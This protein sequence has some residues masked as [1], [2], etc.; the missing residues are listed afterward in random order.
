MWSFS[1][2][3]QPSAFSTTRVPPPPLVPR[4]QARRGPGGGAGGGV[5]FPPVVTSTT[6][7]VLTSTLR[8]S[9]DLAVR[10]QDPLLKL[11]IGHGGWLFWCPDSLLKLAIG[12]GGWQFWCP[13]SFEE[14]AIG[15]GGWPLGNPE[16]HFCTHD[17]LEGLCRLIL[18]SCARPLEA[19]C[20]L[21]SEHGVG[22][23]WVGECRAG[24]SRSTGVDSTG[25]DWGHTF[26]VVQERSA[27]FLCCRRISRRS[28]QTVN[29]DGC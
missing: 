11:A 4:W 2:Q 3:N 8:L 12:H 18:D 24:S 7:C 23:R 10:C 13:D 9:G 29:R 1:R 5:A 17:T 14:F 6:P 15:H 26:F 20:F 19:P 25:V 27:S 21:F 22:E 28:A 16:I